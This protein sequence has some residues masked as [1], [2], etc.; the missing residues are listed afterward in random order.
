[1]IITANYIDRSSRPK[2][3]SFSAELF[4]PYREQIIQQQMVLPMERD[5]GYIEMAQCI[6]DH[7]KGYCVNIDAEQILFYTQNEY[8]AWRVEK[9]PSKTDT[10]SS[11]MLM[12]FVQEPNCI[13]FD[14]NEQ[15]FSEL[16]KFDFIYVFFHDEEYNHIKTI[17]K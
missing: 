3:P 13:Y 2:L 1:V 9:F 12:E 15:K 8:R 14:I 11:K 5:W 6:V 10:I 17:K 7:L 4:S 16:E